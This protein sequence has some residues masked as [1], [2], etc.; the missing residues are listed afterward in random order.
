MSKEIEKKLEEII[1]NYLGVVDV[2]QNHS[3]VD[4]LGAD[5]LDVLGLILDIE[6]GFNVIITDE[7]IEGVKT[8]SDITKIVLEQ[9]K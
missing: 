3:I 8:V 7:Q 1:K 2:N 6:T 9:K 4:D 5:S